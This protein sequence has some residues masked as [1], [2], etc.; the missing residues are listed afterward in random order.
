MMSGTLIIGH[1]LG[2]ANP[3]ADYLAMAL[4]SFVFAPTALY[5][6]HHASVSFVSIFGSSVVPL[7][8]LA[9]G[10]LVSAVDRGEKEWA[11][12]DS[13]IEQAPEAAVLMGADQRVVR[14]NRAFSDLFGYTLGEVAG[15]RLNDLIVPQ[16]AEDEFQAFA[17]A[18]AA[19]RRIDSEA[20]R[21][22]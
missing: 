4:T 20:V 21:C 15:R 18:V 5:S 6:T 22:R 11:L 2:L 14:V 9:A 10:L 19:G 1:F 3:P 13:L 12:L 17:E 16:G 7:L 8:F